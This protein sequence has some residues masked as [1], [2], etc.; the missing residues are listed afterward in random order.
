MRN[1]CELEKLNQ[2]ELGL[3]ENLVLLAYERG[4]QLI[5]E[6]SIDHPDYFE[7]S[8]GEIIREDSPLRE[9]Q[10]DFLNYQ[11]T[12]KDGI[13]EFVGDYIDEE[14]DF[15]DEQFKEKIK[16]APG[17]TVYVERALKYV[18]DP[19][20]LLTSPE[21]ENTA[22]YYI[23]HTAAYQPQKAKDLIELC[24]RDF[25]IKMKDVNENYLHQFEDTIGNYGI[26][27]EEDLKFCFALYGVSKLSLT[28][29]HQ[30]RLRCSTLA[31]YYLK[32]HSYDH[33][34]ADP[35]MI[36]I[37]ENMGL[38]AELAE[39]FAGLEDEETEWEE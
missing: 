21:F 20:E 39:Q 25:A 31:R 4:H 6:G 33:I 34:V 23:F 17:V 29:N 14:A 5:G 22:M 30:V 12:L 8:L 37:A 24:G 7:R 11:Q 2:T 27:N 32:E 1:L 28:D 10:A 38:A 16:N 19:K 9:S 18:A 36:F 3:N 13:I 15:F 26:R 35:V